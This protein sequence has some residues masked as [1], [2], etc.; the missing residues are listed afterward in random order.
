MNHLARSIDI[1]TSHESAA[2]VVSSGL[3]VVQQD[4]AASALKSHPGL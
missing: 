2:H 4:R 1:G 3:Q